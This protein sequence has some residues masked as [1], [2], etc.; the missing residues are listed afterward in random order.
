MQKSRS[1]CYFHVRPANP[2]Y[3]YAIIVCVS[4][5]NYTAATRIVIFVNVGASSDVIYSTVFLAG[6]REDCEEGKA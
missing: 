5:H 3:L 6:A 4:A 1:N 2:A